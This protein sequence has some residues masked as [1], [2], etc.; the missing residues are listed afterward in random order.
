M[1]RQILQ[2]TRETTFGTYASGN[3]HTIIDLPVDNAYTM[4]PEPKFWD[5]VS[6][7]SDNNVVQTGTAETDVDGALQVY[8]RPAQA[9]VLVSMIDGVT[10]GNC[11]DLPSFTIDHGIFIED[12]NC[13]PKMRR[14]LGVKA[15]GGFDLINTGQGILLML[16]LN[17]M[18]STVAAITVSDFAIPT[19]SAYDYVETP[20]TMYMLDGSIEYGG[21]DISQYVESISFAAGNILMPFRGA[22]AFRNRVKYF[23]HRPTVTLKTLYWTQQQRID[24]E[25]NAAKALVLTFTDPAG[26]TLVLDFGNTN[27]L[28]QVGDDLKLG[29]FHRQT[30][31]LKNTVDPA[32]GTD[33]SI[34]YTAFVAP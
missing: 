26:D 22:S 9:A 28:R 15:D 16:K 30:V 3:P 23:G 21:A 12:G 34:T 33:M 17:L 20:F 10:T 8:C 4:R 19:H 29:D 7:A 13:A 31:Q 24:Y 11:P 14:Y 5:I 27:Y 6:M 32:T 18:G 2:I 1:P 25:A